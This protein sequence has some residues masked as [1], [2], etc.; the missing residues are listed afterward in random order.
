MKT[1]V[2]LSLL[3]VWAHSLIGD[4]LEL[5]NGTLLEGTFVG[6]GIISRGI[7]TEPWTHL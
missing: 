1:L 7:R 2:F 4:I 6:N 5:G 3:I